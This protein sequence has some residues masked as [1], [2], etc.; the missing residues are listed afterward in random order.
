MSQIQIPFSTHFHTILFYSFPHKHGNVVSSF[1]KVVVMPCPVMIFL[2]SQNISS[3]CWMDFRRIGE[4][5][6]GLWGTDSIG[7]VLWAKYWKKEEGE[8][9]KSNKTKD[10]HFFVYAITNQHRVTNT[11]AT[12]P[13]RMSGCVNGNSLDTTYSNHFP[14]FVCPNLREFLTAQPPF[15]FPIFTKLLI[16]FH[17]SLVDSQRTLAVLHKLPTEINVILV[18]M[19][20][21][22]KFENRKPHEDQKR[23]QKETKKA[24]Q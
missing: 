11:K 24:K 21:C 19:W 2:S 16:P 9:W 5:F 23:K 20:I 4:S 15:V 12:T 10:K 8:K 14:V 3:R 18:C 22:S 13:G 17:I 1:S 6:T 7:G